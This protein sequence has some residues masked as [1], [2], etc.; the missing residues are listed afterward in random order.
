MTML[1]I[2]IGM[3]ATAAAILDHASG[4]NRKPKVKNKN[5]SHRRSV[6]DDDPFFGTP[7]QKIN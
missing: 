7:L 3:I 1:L 6:W 4:M 2:I 5:K